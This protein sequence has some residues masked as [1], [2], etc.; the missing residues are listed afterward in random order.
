M[1]G[2]PPA[3]ISANPRSHR[4]L[5]GKRI[6]Q[7]TP[8]L[9]QRFTD[10]KLR[11]YSLPN[12][13]TPSRATSGAQPITESERGRAHLVSI[14]RSTTSCSII[15]SIIICIIFMRP[16]IFLCIFIMP[17]IIISPP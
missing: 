6:N 3:Q 7:Y 13:A 5:R 12:S 11:D 4:G 15:C 1:Y 17:P 16:T 14:S 10:I 9:Q 2:L 8:F